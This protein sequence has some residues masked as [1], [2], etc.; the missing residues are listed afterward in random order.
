MSVS[1]VRGAVGFALRTAMERAVVPC[2]KLSFGALS[3]AASGLINI[4]STGSLKAL[5]TSLSVMLGGS[6][7]VFSAVPFGSLV[8]WSATPPSKIIYVGMQVFN[9]TV[10]AGGALFQTGY[11]ASIGKIP[12]Y[13]GSV[14]NFPIPYLVSLEEALLT[15]KYG[16]AVI[17]GVVQA[18]V[19]SSTLSKAGDAA[20]KCF[21]LLVCKGGNKPAA[22]VLNNHSSVR[23]YSLCEQLGVSAMAVSRAV[24]WG[25]ASVVMHKSI[26]DVSEDSS[27][28][29]VTGYVFSAIVL[30]GLLR[31]KCRKPLVPDNNAFHFAVDGPRNTYIQH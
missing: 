6:E 31:D 22:S 15:S 5:S 27:V 28:A 25:I 7:Y 17:L 14:L 24:G 13:V 20:K 1:F 23:K 30:A 2:C 18:Y 10:L 21:L 8:D 11:E 19:V 4:V 29:T 16:N 26:V 3:S 12:F 9:Q